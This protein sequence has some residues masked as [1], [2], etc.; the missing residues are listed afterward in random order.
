MVDLCAFDFDLRL[1]LF[2]C[3]VVKEIERINAKELE[4]GSKSS[5]HV[6]C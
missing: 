4:L 3:S 5:W 1:E 2:F 6:S